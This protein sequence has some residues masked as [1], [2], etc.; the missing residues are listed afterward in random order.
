MN[1]L[2]LSLLH[3]ELLGRFRSKRRLCHVSF[4]I[5]RKCLGDRQLQGIPV[6]G[7]SVACMKEFGLSDTFTVTLT[8]CLFRIFTFEQS[9]LNPVTV[10][11]YLVVLTVLEYSCA[12][13]FAKISGHYFS[14]VAR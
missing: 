2:I 9:I 6:R 11:N 13:I 10:A 5:N 3:S 7:V 1:L 12:L 4:M 14:I 8:V